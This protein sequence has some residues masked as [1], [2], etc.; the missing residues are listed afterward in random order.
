MIEAPSP[1]AKLHQVQTSWGYA[2][3]SHSLMRMVLLPWEEEHNMTEWL[4]QKKCKLRS[5]EDLRGLRGGEQKYE[6]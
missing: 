1:P 5:R 2:S 6:V 3:S 4:L